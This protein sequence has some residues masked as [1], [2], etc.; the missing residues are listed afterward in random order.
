ML[1]WNCTILL[2]NPPLVLLMLRPGSTTEMGEIALIDLFLFF[3][4][5]ELNVFIARSNVH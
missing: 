3:F 4:L 2:T 5:F 1:R